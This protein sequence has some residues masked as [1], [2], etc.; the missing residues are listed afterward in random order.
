MCLGVYIGAFIGDGV[1]KVEFWGQSIL[2]FCCFVLFFNLRCAKVY[3]KGSCANLM[4]PSTTDKA[5]CFPTFF[6]N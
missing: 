3:S 1:L 4:F 6:S 5:G 2:L